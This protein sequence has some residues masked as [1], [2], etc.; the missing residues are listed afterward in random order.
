MRT[1]GHSR[2]ARLIIADFAP[3]QSGIRIGREM[4]GWVIRAG[5]G[6]CGKAVEE[7]EPDRRGGPLFLAEDQIDGPTTADVGAP[8]PAV[9][10]EPVVVAPG[11]HE[12]VGQ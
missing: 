8:T 1:I 3:G 10:E 6:I 12:G 11:V 5:P 9:V 2:N 4:R 7:L